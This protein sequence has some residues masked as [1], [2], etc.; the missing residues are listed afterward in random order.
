MGPGGRPWPRLEEGGQ[1]VL[2]GWLQGRQVGGVPPAGSSVETHCEEGAPLKSRTM[3]RQR[4]G[5]M[6]WD[7]QH[8]LH[9]PGTENGGGAGASKASRPR[10]AHCVSSPGLRAAPTRNSTGHAAC[11]LPGA[12]GPQLRSRQSSDTPTA[13]RGCSSRSPWCPSP[14]HTPDQHAWRRTPALAPG[15]DS[16]STHHQPPR[17]L[18]HC[19]PG[20]P[21]AGDLQPTLNS[22][23]A[24]EGARWQPLDREVT[25]TGVPPARSFRLLQY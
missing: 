10:G 14:T 19:S 2:Q 18:H 9:V 3:P 13:T 8:L 12:L 20:P 1:G 21:L 17:P 23:S 22:R 4:T 16:Q 7:R 24:L 25:A 5:P 6:A 15:Q 11:L